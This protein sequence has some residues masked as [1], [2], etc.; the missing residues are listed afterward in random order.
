MKLDRTFSVSVSLIVVGC[1]ENR[2]ATNRFK[3]T[4]IESTSPTSA[5]RVNPSAFTTC[6]EAVEIKRAK[7]TREEQETVK[8]DTCSADQRYARSKVKAI[9]SVGAADL[10][11]VSDLA[12]NY[13][14]R[15]IL[16]RYEFVEWGRWFCN[17][18]R[19]RFRLESRPLPIIARTLL[20][21][22]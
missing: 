1:D 13:R 16:P 4:R 9:R 5:C 3:K 18:S 7:M 11:P 15:T 17:V 14:N 10:K 19:S 2:T 22:C 8:S 20:K 12:Q 6:G 21:L